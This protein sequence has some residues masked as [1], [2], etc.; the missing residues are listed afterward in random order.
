MNA[1]F[2]LSTVITLAMAAASPAQDATPTASPVASLTDTPPTSPSP[3]P[4]PTPAPAAHRQVRITF[5]PPPLEG[6]IS[7]GI[8]DGTGKLVRILAREAELDDFDAGA[9]ALSTKWDGNDDAGQPLPS[10]KYR[11]RGYAVGDLHVEESTGAMVEPAPSAVPKIS[12]KLIANPLT[13]GK[14]Q[15]VELA[16]GYD[17]DGTF[18]QTADGLPLF[19]VDE[20]PGVYAVTLA[21]R[22]EKS[23]E[24]TQ[25]DGD[26]TDTFRLANFDQMMEFDCGEI[27][28]R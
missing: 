12:V 13:G 26:T 22:S 4:S 11:A 10:G 27:Q 2:L 15:S 23:L 7:L 17:D 18:L 19:T 5:L 1:R 20:M 24:F 6:T 28:L 14:R 3:S 8:Y 21:R 9:D 25:N 16:A